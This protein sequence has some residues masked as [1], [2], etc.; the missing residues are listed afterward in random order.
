MSWKRKANDKL[1]AVASGL[2]WRNSSVETM[3][4]FLR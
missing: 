2:S 3:L 4:P 1:A